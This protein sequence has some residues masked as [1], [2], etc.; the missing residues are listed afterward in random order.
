VEELLGEISSRELT[1]WFAFD[2]V[3]PIG[4]RRGDLQAGVVAATVANVNRAKGSREYR[5]TDFVPEY[6]KREE[7]II[8]EALVMQQVGLWNALKSRTNEE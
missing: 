3:E 8:A 7:T 6:G 1:E 4:G 5:I 2:Q